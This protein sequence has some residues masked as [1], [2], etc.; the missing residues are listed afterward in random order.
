MF[1]YVLPFYDE[2]DVEVLA[3]EEGALAERVS[4]RQP[5]NP[6]GHRLDGEGLMAVCSLFRMRASERPTEE[7]RAQFR[8]AIEH[9]Y[10]EPGWTYQLVWRR[11]FTRRTHRRAEWRGDKALGP[12]VATAPGGGG[13]ESFDFARAH[14]LSRASRDPYKRTVKR[15]ASRR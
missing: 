4:L 12:Y 15:R 5:S 9:N 6:L 13:R 14:W 11:H 1:Q 3:T 10:L 8:R 7:L 2:Y